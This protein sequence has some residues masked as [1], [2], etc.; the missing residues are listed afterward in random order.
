MFLKT[1]GGRPSRMGKK[2]W[3]EEHEKGDIIGLTE[4][5]ETSPRLEG[6]LLRSCLAGWRM[7][8]MNDAES[9][10]GHETQAWGS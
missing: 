7:S 1:S 8:E 9:H 6:E 3:R 5:G 4:A 10:V 2:G